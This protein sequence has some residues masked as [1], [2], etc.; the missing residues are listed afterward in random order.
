MVQ[1]G[2]AATKP[3]HRETRN[4][5]VSPWAHATFGI[6]SS[7]RHTRSVRSPHRSSMGSSVIA[8]LGQ[9]FSDTYLTRRKRSPC[10][11]VSGAPAAGSPSR[12]I[13]QGQ[14]FSDTYL[15]RRKRSPCWAVS[16]APGGRAPTCPSV[17]S[18]V[19]G[20]WILMTEARIMLGWTTGQGT[21]PSVCRPMVDGRAQ[22]ARTGVDEMLRAPSRL[23]SPMGV[24]RSS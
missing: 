7:P 5:G 14:S 3:Y 13:I 4:I 21:S 19:P 18:A 6:P 1:P 20:R 17:S 15:T 2:C 8:V 11:A 16:G 24:R 9:S 10:W 22:R 23:S 12:T